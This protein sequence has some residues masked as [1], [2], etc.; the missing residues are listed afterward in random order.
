LA[1]HSA[2]QN[3]GTT[4]VVTFD[5]HAFDVG[6]Y[7]GTANRLTV[8]AGGDGYYQIAGYVSFSGGSNYVT[9]RRNGTDVIAFAPGVSAAG[10]ACSAEIHALEY[11]AAGDYVQLLVYGGSLTAYH[12][13]SHGP[14]LSIR[15]LGT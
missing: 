9:L 4:G 1:Y 12:N 7:H 8:P 14:R 10:G 3:C 2:D 5:S 15:K 13:I 6:G 11:L